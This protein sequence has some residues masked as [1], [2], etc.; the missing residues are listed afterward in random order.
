M[1]V[2]R[3][4]S[5]VKTD[6]HQFHIDPVQ[7]DSIPDGVYPEFTLAVFGGQSIRV[8]V[9]IRVGPVNLVL[10]MHDSPP[11]YVDAEWEDAVEG[12][13]FY[14]NPG[15]VVVWHFYSGGFDQAIPETPGQTLTPP[16]K[17]RYRVRIYACGRDIE[18]DGPLV[19]DPVEDYL[20]QMW[21]TTE[22]EP[23]REI[24][25]LSGR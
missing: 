25:N 24:K 22:P 18:Y 21:P 1:L 10:E 8:G 7:S 17:H 23:A 14:D 2:E 13:L 16:G 12:D 15:G 11:P 4:Q 19:G 20:I 6:Y 5:V 3:F 9:G